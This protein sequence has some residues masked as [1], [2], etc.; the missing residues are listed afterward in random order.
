M[1]ISN[2]RLLLEEIITAI[3]AY[4]K[5]HNFIAKHKLWKWILIPGV[6]YAILFAIGIYVF[7]QSS[8][9]VIDYFF[10]KTGLKI[11]LQKEQDGGLRFI[12]IF[13]QLILQIILM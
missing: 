13:G 2:T 11:W 4:F 10:S 3:R 12:F 7:W 9:H 1:V 8:A 5:A 6:I